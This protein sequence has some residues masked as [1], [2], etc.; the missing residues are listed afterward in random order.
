[1]KDSFSIGL[2]N[3]IEYEYDEF[4]VKELYNKEW[5]N[6]NTVCIQIKLGV[7]SNGKDVIVVFV[8]FRGT[9]QKITQYVIYN[10]KVYRQPFKELKTVPKEVQYALK[11]F[12][13][14][15]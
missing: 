8:H 13:I 15:F 14:K 11:E 12:D 7:D 10:S 3:N 5:F 9:Y 4:K 2:F 1:M 6:K